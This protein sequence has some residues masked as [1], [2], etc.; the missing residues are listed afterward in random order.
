MYGAER[1]YLLF[2]ETRDHPSSA[3]KDVVTHLVLHFDVENPTSLSRPYPLHGWCVSC[4]NFDESEERIPQSKQD[5]TEQSHDLVSGQGF[6][7]LGKW[8]VLEGV[9]FRGA[10][11]AQGA[12]AGV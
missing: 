10:E 3:V 9:V 5:K 7:G 6:L 2:G 12:E 11:L 4:G 8:A 1:T